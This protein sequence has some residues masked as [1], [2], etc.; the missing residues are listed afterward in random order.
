M[1]KAGFGF[2]LATIIVLVGGSFLIYKYLEKLK[3][4]CDD[5]S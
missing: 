1:E 4:E 5:Y 3:K 2:I